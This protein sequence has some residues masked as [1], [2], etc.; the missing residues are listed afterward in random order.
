MHFSSTTLILLANLQAA[1]S[2]VSQALTQPASTTAFI[3]QHSSSSSTTRLSVAAT[4]LPFESTI[5]SENVASSVHRDVDFTFAIIDVNGNGFLSQDELNTHLSVAGYPEDVI[6]NFFSKMDANQDGLI[7]RDE[8]RWGMNSRFETLQ[9][10][11][12]LGNY[13]SQFIEEIYEDADQVFQSAD[14][15][16]NG[17]INEFEMQSHLGRIFGKYSRAAVE[18]IFKILDVNDDQSISQQEL[19]DA[20]VRSSALRQVIGEGPNYK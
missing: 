10:A 12:G 17:E 1:T 20:F 16:G 19:R 4:M 7:S 15:D 13:N 6:R 5:T 8:F 18:T 11:P 14:A 2:F 3:R 9:A